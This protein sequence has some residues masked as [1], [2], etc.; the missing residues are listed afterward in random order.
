MSQGEDISEADYKRYWS[1]T[2]QQRSQKIQDEQVS[3]DLKAV[4]LFQQG[5][6][7][8]EAKDYERAIV[9]YDKALELKPD[10]Y[11]SWN[12]RGRALYFLNRYQEAIA[13]YDKALAIQPG[14][15]SAWDNR[16][17]VLVYLKRYE[18]AIASYDKALAIQPNYYYAWNSRGVTLHFLN[19]YEE[20]IASYNK[21]LE[22]QP[23]SHFMTWFNRGKALYSLGRYEEAVLS[24][25]RA[26]EIKPDF[27]TATLYKL[28]ILVKTGK[29]LQSFTRSSLKSNSKPTFNQTLK[30]LTAFIA[31]L[32]NLVFNTRLK[33]VLLFAAT[34]ILVFYYGSDTWVELLKQVLSV[35]FS[36]A[37]FGM[38]AG[39]IWKKRSNLNFVWNIYFKSGILSYVRAFAI[40]LI[41]IVCGI[42]LYI[43]APE[44]MKWGWGSLIFGDSSNIALQPIDTASQAAEKINQIQGTGL[45]FKWLF[46]SPVWLLFILALPFWAEAEEKIFRKGVHSWKGI[47]IRSLI[48]GL[49]HLTMGIPIIWALNLAIPGFLFACRYKYVYH[50][51]LKK[52]HNEQKAQEA[53]VAASTADHA[54]YNAILITFSVAVILFAE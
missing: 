46:I 2:P 37:I 29:V 5:L 51:H 12:S 33:Y 11:Y 25:N 38:I 41:T 3:A 9:S 15:Y 7:F 39:E 31:A 54:I 42:I 36:L 48:F 49:V 13:S 34:L 18:E 28:L 23:N 50:R 21:A 26:L 35:L 20:A 45:D 10:H 32:V 22:I 19:R 16:G 27:H 8:A 14:Y 43:H 24:Y 40:V 1:L 52:N 6:V 53:G 30:K 47:T 44:F 17:D 4:L